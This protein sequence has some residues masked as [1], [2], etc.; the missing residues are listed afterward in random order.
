ER[1]IMSAVVD[2]I[3]LTL[4]PLRRWRLVTEQL[5]TGRTPSAILEQQSVEWTQFAVAKTPCPGIAVLRARAAAALD[6]AGRN[7]IDY[8]AW[9]DPRYPAALAA[10]A[11]PPPVLWIRGRLSS[12]DAPSV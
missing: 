2:L 9:S 1:G 3:A 7:G 10:I 6:R 11:D 8:L 12:L 5:Q 4:L